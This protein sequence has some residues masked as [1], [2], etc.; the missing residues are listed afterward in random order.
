MQHS[1]PK[2]KGIGDEWWSPTMPIKSKNWFTLETH[3]ALR[4][5]HYCLFMEYVQTIRLKAWVNLTLSFYAFLKSDCAVCHTIPN[6]PC[7]AL[8]G[9]HQRATADTRT[10][11]RDAG[12]NKREMTPAATCRRLLPGNRP[13]RA[14]PTQA[15]LSKLLAGYC[16]KAVARLWP[17]KNS[18]RN[19]RRETWTALD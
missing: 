10:L 15:G 18:A 17:Q 14:F 8:D 3:H 9:Q 16:E 7:S 19:V 4:A 6:T 1:Q 11:W 2:N 13:Q 12:R 5:L